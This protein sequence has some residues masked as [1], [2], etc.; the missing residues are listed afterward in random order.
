M[1]FEGLGGGVFGEYIVEEGAGLNGGEHRGSGRCDNVACE[2]SVELFS[3]LG[4]GVR[5]DN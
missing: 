5:I 4:I 2:S 3:K 1:G